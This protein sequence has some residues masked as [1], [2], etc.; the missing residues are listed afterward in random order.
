MAKLRHIAI[1]VPDPARSARFYCDVF[2][3]QV[4]GETDS[5]LASGVYLSD[6]TVCLAL[7]NYKTDEAAGL[8]RGRD[9]VGV[10][11]FG[12]WCDDLDSQTTQVESHGGTFFMELPVAKDSL[13]FEAK[14]RDP[15]GVVFDV[16]HNGWV[17]A[18]R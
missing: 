5:P 12:F 1:A 4:V 2:D 16:S 18:T 3:M 14:F 9:Y 11:H 15:D 17:G 6:G 8:E 7:L 10:H 13:Y